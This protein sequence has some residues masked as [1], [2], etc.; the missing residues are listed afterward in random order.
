M[1]N[2]ADKTRSCSEFREN[3]IHLLV[4]LYFSKSISFL[5]PFRIRELILIMK[6]FALGVEIHH[7][8]MDR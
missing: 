5:L 6:I 8:K 4:K 3:D 1:Q 2:I 7:N